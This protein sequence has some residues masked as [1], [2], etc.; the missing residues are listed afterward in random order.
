[1]KYLKKFN[2]S[3][4]TKDIIDNLHQLCMDFKDDH[5]I[6][7]VYPGK[8]IMV[9]IKA[10]QASDSIKF[11][12][13]ILTILSII[14]Y[15]NREEYHT[16]LILNECYYKHK[17][18]GSIYRSSLPIDGSDFI[19]AYDNNKDINDKDNIEWEH[20]L[21]LDD[22]SISRTIDLVFRPLTQGQRK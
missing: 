5:L 15:M 12:K 18:Y 4:D 21:K 11:R 7:E 20:S 10:N 14:E 1:M 13:Y 9:N 22:I 17:N 19:K 6:V 3:I 8:V 2:E 16:N